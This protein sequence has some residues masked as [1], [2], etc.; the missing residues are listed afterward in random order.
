MSPYL[1]R[2]FPCLM[3]LYLSTSGLVQRPNYSVSMRR[4]HVSFKCK[5]LGENIKCKDKIWGKITICFLSFCSSD[6]QKLWKCV[7]FAK[8]VFFADS[9][10]QKSAAHRIFIQ[11]QSEHLDDSIFVWN[12]DVAETYLQIEEEKI[13]LFQYQPLSMC[14][15]WH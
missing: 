6:F 1:I 4:L 11:S 9:I 7:S 3:C 15:N 13:W 10:L 12:W 5:D 2:Q 8:D 14:H